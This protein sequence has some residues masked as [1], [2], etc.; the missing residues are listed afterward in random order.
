MSNHC[1]QWND[2]DYTYRKEI[3]IDKKLI[4]GELEDFPICISITSDTDLSNHSESTNGF[5]II[6]YDCEGNLLDHELNYYNTGSVVAWSKG[7]FGRSI[8]FWVWRPMAG[9]TIARS[10][11][12]LRGGKKSRCSMAA[13]TGS[14]A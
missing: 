10:T 5:D 11:V 7:R 1:L 6:F 9:S 14:I 8:C 3:I 12:V 4:G 13:K 2:T